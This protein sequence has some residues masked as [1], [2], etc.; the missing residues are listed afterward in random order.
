VIPPAEPNA[1]SREDSTARIAGFH[2]DAPVEEG[3]VR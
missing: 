1:A 2:L 3:E